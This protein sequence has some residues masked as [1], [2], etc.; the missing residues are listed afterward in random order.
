MT[1]K[2]VYEVTVKQN[3]DPTAP[4]AFV[5]INLEE[6][7]YTEFVDWTDNGEEVHAIYTNL[8]IDAKLD[9]SNL[10][11]GYRISDGYGNYF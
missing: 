10:V 9:S 5:G 6:G 3:D 11:K 8:D 4:D 1:H 7:G 2:Y